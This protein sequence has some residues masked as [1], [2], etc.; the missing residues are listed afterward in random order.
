M[1]FLIAAGSGLGI[2]GGATLPSSFTVGSGL[3]IA[4]FFL[5]LTGFRIDQK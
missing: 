3:C 1:R 5:I 4:A 2:A